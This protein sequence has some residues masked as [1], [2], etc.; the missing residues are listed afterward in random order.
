MK[1]DI[2]QNERDFQEA[3]NIY[4]S[5]GSS[6]KVASAA[7][8]MF[9]CIYNACTNIALSIY[10]KRGFVVAGTDKVDEAAMEATLICMRNIEERGHRPNKL[11]SYCYMRVLAEVNK[12]D[13]FHT[14]ICQKIIETTPQLS[15][16]QEFVGK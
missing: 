3:L 2:D 12:R 14:R 16:I 13:D 8:K 15:D 11:S 7:E 5:E 4:V 1:V 6:E 10:K 9:T